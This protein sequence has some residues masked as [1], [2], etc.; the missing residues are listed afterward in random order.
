MRRQG[1]DLERLGAAADVV[2]VKGI[3]HVQMEPI[4][5]GSVDTAAEL[6]ASCAFGLV[7]MGYRDVLSELAVL[8]ADPEKVARTAA[9]Q[10]LGHCGSDAA[11]PL[12]KFKALIGDKDAEVVGECFTAMLKLAPQRSVDFVAGFLESIDSDVRGAAALALGASRLH[13][14]FERLRDQWQRS[15]HPD[16]RRVLCLAIASARF[17]AAVEF[18]LSMIVEQPPQTA[19]DAIAALALYRQ[20]AAV[21]GQ[22]SAAVARRADPAISRAFREEFGG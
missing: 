14:A 21:K 15:V 5:G 8:L 2:F 1:R 13:S 19:A 22:V 16:F 10:A 18:L 20:D 6:R 7:R 17:D 4:W 3:H 9:V 11:L 12:L